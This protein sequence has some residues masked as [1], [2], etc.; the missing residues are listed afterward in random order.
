MLSLLSVEFFSGKLN[1]ACFYNAT[2]DAVDADRPCVTS[3]PGLIL[4]LPVCLFFL[5]CFVFCF[6]VFLFVHVFV[7][8][9]LIAFACSHTRSSFIFLSLFLPYSPIF[10]HSHASSKGHLCDAD[11]QFCDVS[12]GPGNGA[13][14]FDNIGLAMLT[15]FQCITMEGWTDIMYWVSTLLLHINTC[16]HTH[17]HTH[18][19][20]LSL[21]PSLSLSLSLSFS[22]PLSF[23]PSSKSPPFVI[24]TI[25]FCTGVRWSRPLHSLAV[26]RDT[27]Y[28]RHFHDPQ[29]CARCYQ[30]AVCEGNNRRKKSNQLFFTSSNVLNTCAD[31]FFLSFFFS[32]FFF[33][34]QEGERSERE[35]EFRKN[36]THHVRQ[37]SIHFL[38]LFNPLNLVH[39]PQ[40]LSF[41]KSEA[42]YLAE[43]DEWIDR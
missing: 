1:S 37:H 38:S 18:S 42:A 7:H 33:L 39:L 14:S 2:G 11:Y 35:K 23:S 15:V 13:V 36:H 21:S 19:L 34:I 25:K 30:R 3:S 20:S 4:F 28:F 17:T 32:F 27:D 12:T 5:F 43:Y 41:F 9:G 10:C 22:L 24:L 29:P 26:L 16:T 40:M 6:C 31:S 8:F